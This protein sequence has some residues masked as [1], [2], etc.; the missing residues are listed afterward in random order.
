[1]K[2]KITQP[3]LLQ[4]STPLQ[5]AASTVISG[6]VCMKIGDMLHGRTGQ[7]LGLMAGLVAGFFGYIAVIIKKEQ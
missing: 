4:I 5:L 1:M 2:L 7:I 3:D 6:L